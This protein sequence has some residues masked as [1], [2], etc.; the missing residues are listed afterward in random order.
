MKLP[1]PDLI[2]FIALTCG[3]VIFE[4]VF[5][6]KDKPYRQFTSGEG[7][8]PVWIVEMS[9]LYTL[10]SSISLLSIY[11]VVLAPYLPITTLILALAPGQEYMLQYAICYHH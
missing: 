9:I 1:K 10:I 4:S 11:R 2:D 5:F 3:N 8:L 6:F 7:K